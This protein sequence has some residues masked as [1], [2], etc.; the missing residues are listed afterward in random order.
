MSLYQCVFTGGLN[1]RAAPSLTA[2]VVCRHLLFSSYLSYHII[3][4]MNGVDMY[5]MPHGTW[6]G[7]NNGTNVIDGHIIIW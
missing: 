6:V 7:Y 1:A 4:H 5:T 2:L 3:S